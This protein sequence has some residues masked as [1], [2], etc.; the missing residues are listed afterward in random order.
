MPSAKSKQPTRFYTAPHWPQSSTS[1]W[2]QK[3]CPIRLWVQHIKSQDL[4]DCHCEWIRT[5]ATSPH[6]SPSGLTQRMSP[7][8]GQR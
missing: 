6:L 5:P 3:D 1:A 4:R 8:S 7:L 2:R